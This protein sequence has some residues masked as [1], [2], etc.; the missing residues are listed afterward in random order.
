M[1]VR[2][3][4]LAVGAVALA[5]AGAGVLAG[6][7]AALA[8]GGGG[9]TPPWQSQFTPNGSITFYNA[10]G[11][12]V[13]GGSIT[14]S[15]LAAY[16][17]ASTPDTR[18]GDTKATLQMFTP[19]NGVAPG[20]WTGATM[21]IATTYPITT[22]PAPVGTTANPVN[23]NLNSFS[24]SIATYI[25]G[26]PNN[27]TS[28]TDG[29]AGLYDVRLA[30]SGLGIGTE[31]TYWD[32]VISVNQAAGTWSVDYP[33]WTQNTTTTLTATPPSPQTAPASQTTLTATVAPAT[34]GTV[35]FW[36]G[37]TQV[38]TT[39]TVTATN[40]VATVT[41]TPP[42][43]TT[44]YQAI[45]TPAVG[46]SD[47][48]SS[49]TLSYVVNTPK[50]ATSTTLAQSGGGG[51]AGP[52]TFTGTV[53]DTTT[54]S[55]TITSGTVSL[56]DN[57]STT[58]FASGAV[59]SGGNYSINFTYSS[60]GSHSVVATFVPASGANF[61]GSSSSAVTFTEAAP[62]CTTCNDVQT[63]TGTIPAGT[64][65]ISTP[66]TPANPLNLGT[67]A[68]TPDGSYFTASAKLDAN[69]SNVPTAGQYPN[70]TFNG[71]T[72]VDTQSGSLP[73]TASAAASNLSDGTGHATGAISGENVGLTGLTPVLVP[74][75]AIVAGDVTV[76]NQSAATP[77]VAPTDPGSAG[78]GGS[79]H[80]IASDSAQPT[81]TVGING[82][83][84]L[85]APTST[86]A[87]IFTG[88]ITF[89]I[90]G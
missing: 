27:D 9:P 20:A 5:M 56:Y 87:G 33:N 36:N 73:W 70:T 89:T 71:I 80:V 17:V 77:P 59:G 37:S 1:K 78:L 12:V 14:A 72:V 7:G 79:P 75:N 54:P 67:L 55:T 44:P 63:I 25:N 13:T 69:A 74:G 24:E 49:G 39:Q 83:V 52:V 64:I 57:G 45:F 40:G 61:A 90:A 86:E 85:N 50:D 42:A 82:T 4:S 2:V 84:T 46:S 26:N 15:G 29:Y 38:G 31:A 81:G 58:A 22:A 21:G 28:T 43:G 65:S 47:I 10:Q 60:A 3:R 34:A 32:T 41:T 76:T 23:N 62:A 18:S 6:G 53:T 8:A 48:G 68:L 16:A 11:Q 35:S 51:P 66:Y 88:T 19:V 30:V